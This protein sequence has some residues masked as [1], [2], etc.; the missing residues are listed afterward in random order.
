MVSVP[1]L[2][3]YICAKFAAVGLSE[4]LRTELGQEG[5][6]VTTVVPG[7]MRTGSYVQAHFMDYRHIC[8]GSFTI[9]RR[10]VMAVCCPPIS[11]CI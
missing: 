3:S 6:R 10:Q 9:P 8:A 11:I 1:H 2:L 7:L 4:G 5:I